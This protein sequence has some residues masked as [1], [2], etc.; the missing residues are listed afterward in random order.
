MP[1][2]TFE[3]A[4]RITNASEYGLTAAVYTKDAVKANRAAR[5]V[6]VGMVWVNNYNRSILGTPF[7]GV[8]SSGY[9]REHCI[10]TLY[11]WMTTK[12]IHTPSGLGTIP[13]WR[14]VDEIFEEDG[15]SSS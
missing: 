1:F 8:K 6:E 4:V 13:P 10:E 2:D 12:A 9:G 14:A 11:D 3:D 7:G 5:A 15:V